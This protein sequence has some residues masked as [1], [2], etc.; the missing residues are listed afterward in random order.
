MDKYEYKLKTE[1]MLE[2]MEDGAYSRAAELADSIDWR[3]VRNTTMLMNVSDI[4]E[5]SRDYH[6]SFEVLKIAYHRAEGSRKIVYRLCTLALKTRNVDEAIDYYDEF[7]HIAPK[8]PNQYILKYQILK[9]QRAPIEQ[10]IDALESFKKAEYVEEWAYELAKLYER[11][12]K[13]TECLEE[14]DDLILWFSE[15]KYVYQAMELK[16]R[17]KPLTPSQQEKYNRRYEKPGTTTEELPDLNNVDENGV[18]VAAKSVTTTQEQTEED[19]VKTEEK[20][21]S[22]KSAESEQ[23]IKIPVVEETLANKFVDEDVVKAEVRAKAKAEIL[24]EAD[25]F[26]P[27]SIDS[28]TESIRKAA[29]TETVEQEK[30]EEKEEQESEEIA[31]KTESSEDVKE[32]VLDP[33]ADSVEVKTESEV[34]EKQP[35]KKKIGNTMRLDE[36]LKALLHIGGSDSGSRESSDEEAE[37][38]D[39]DLS[40][41]ND[42][43]ED[44]ED[45]VDLSLVQ[46]VEQKRVQKKAL[47]AVK[48]VK[49][50]SDLEELSMKKLKSKPE[51]TVNLD[52]TLPMNLDDTVEMSPEEIIAMYG[53]TEEAIEEEPEAEEIIEPEEEEIIEEEPEAEEIIEPEEEEILEEEPEAEEIIEPKEEEIIEEEPEAEEIIEPEEEEIIEEEP[54]AEEIIEPEEEEIIEEEPEAEEIIEPEEEEIIE[55]EPEAEEV[56]EP[57]YAEEETIDEDEIFEVEQVL[58]AKYIE[59]EDEEEDQ[60][61]NQV[62]ARMSLE[63]LFAAWDEEDALAEA[64][65]FEEP[66]AEEIIE[67]EAE[68]VIEEEPEAEEIIEPEEEEILEEEPEAEE[69]EEISEEDILNLDSA[70]EWSDDELTDAFEENLDNKAESVEKIDEAL[71]EA[72]SVKD[73]KQAEPEKEETMSV[74]RKTGE[75][76]LPPDIQRLIDEIEGVIPR[77]DE[78]PMSESSTSA[79]KMQERMPEDNMEQEMD[80]LRVDD[81]DEYEDEYEDEYADEFPVEE[82]ESLEAVQPQGGY[83]QEFERIMD[84]RFAS[85]EAEEDYSDELGDLYPDMEDDISDEVDAIALEEEAFEQETEI[86]SP[87]YEDDEYPEEEYEDEYE[88]DEYPEE[89]YEDEYEDDE[90]PEEEYEDEYDEYPEEE[91]E[92]E[93]EDD[94]YP[95]E[96]YEDEY[97]DDEYPEEEYEDEYEDDEYPEEEYEDEYEDD[98]YPEEEYED[99]YEDDEY[100]EDEYEDEYEYEDDEEYGAAD[101]AAQ[102]EAE[103]RPQSS[104]DEYDDRLMD[105]EDDDAGVN[106][107]SK[108]AP[109]SRKETAKLIATG[110]TAPLP[111]DEISNAL[112]ISDTGFLVHNRHELLSESGKKKTEL[113]ADQKRLFSYF[114]PVRGMSEQLVDVLEQDKNCTNRRGTSR[115]GNLLIIGNKGNGKTVLAVDVV[116]AIQRQRN[117]HQGKVA[118]VTGES[119]NKKKIGEIF[120]K[121]YGGALIIEKAGKL[122]ERTVA[123]L[124]KVMEQDTGELLIVLEDQRKPLDRL[125]SSNREFRK[126]FTSRLEVPIFINDELVTFGQTYAQENGYR[127]DEMGLLALYSRID[128]L[129]REDHFVTVAEVKEIMDEA[130]EHSKKAS[131]RKLVKRVFGKGT[132]EADRI[133]LTEKDFHI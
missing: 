10:Q 70:E 80:M 2:L 18:K 79:S 107:L 27:T 121:L 130:M 21:E 109:L 101:A 29:E 62:T 55:E 45:V 47:E 131:A 15:G 132:D 56:I 58:E 102:F 11:A 48:D 76:I 127:I 42:A 39:D 94:E 60:L 20:A 65:E 30:L 124:N 35:E 63:E 12:G 24:G 49:V 72:E 52:D 123:K 67:P 116:K 1:Q 110:K 90:Y 84:D 34:E 117:I 5:K 50:D 73:I 46:R 93:Y 99:E 14:C 129:Q 97:E 105:D 22:D 113:T 125:L 119:L 95:E 7:L 104:N 4:Y 69:T 26:E 66:E 91:Y 86:D 13:I 108:T 122:N 37:K 75:P 28:L 112:S 61:D 78:E 8:D 38:K 111:L 92:D 44:I 32:Q 19:A 120:R 54:E 71:N 106:F 85:F 81:S 25:S 89:E 115:T 43:I 82:E 51:T 40:D 68:E 114:V 64:E 33:K 128:A 96:E 53:G 100:P 31:E 74:E 118:I 87:E 59:P 98:E 3:R 57:E 88:D 16:M 9:V 83:T 23:D 77:E 133:L 126:K 36:A 17:Y 41:L 103:F 6:K